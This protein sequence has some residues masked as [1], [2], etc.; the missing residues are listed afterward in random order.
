MPVE[1]QNLVYAIF[2]KAF[3]DYAHLRH[4]G[5]TKNWIKDEGGY[6]IKEIRDF[7][8]SDWCEDLLKSIGANMTG[9]EL[10]RKLKIKHGEWVAS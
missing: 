5:V 4:L 10:I 7:L 1:Y 2:Q 8:R 6:S 3:N 9:E